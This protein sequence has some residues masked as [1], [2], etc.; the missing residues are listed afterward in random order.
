MK[1]RATILEISGKERYEIIKATISR[2]NTA[3][4][5]SFFLEATALM[6]SLISDRLES[7]LGKLKEDSISFNTFGN[8]LQ[9]LREVEK[10]PLLW[11]S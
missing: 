3:I 10:D 7:R 4:E 8:L 9:L 2:Y 5:H 6:E 1:T 11:K